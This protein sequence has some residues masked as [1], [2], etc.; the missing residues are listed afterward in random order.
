MRR[1]RM[2]LL[3][4]LTM[5]AA[6]VAASTGSAMAADAAQLGR[7]VFYQSPDFTGPT[8]AVSY[9]NCQT[10]SQHQ[11]GLSP[12]SAFDNQ[13]LPGCQVLLINVAGG[14]RVL[15]DGRGVV[16]VE[17]RQNPRV[18]IQ[19]GTSQPCGIGATG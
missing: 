10:P 8:A 16:P 6:V 17:F 3:S 14:T 12:V 11:P 7:V 18:R 5:A 13:P 9:V 19:P 2:V 1:V 4:G 15:C